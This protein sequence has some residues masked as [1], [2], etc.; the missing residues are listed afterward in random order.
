ME[1]F[2]SR[3]RAYHF[4]AAYIGV[5][6][7]LSVL[8]YYVASKS[9]F[10]DSRPAPMTHKFATDLAYYDM[11]RLTVALGSGDQATRVRLD[12]SLEVAKNDVGI[13][14][15]YQPRITARLNRF[16]TTLDPARIQEAGLMPWLRA[17]MLRQVN[18]AGAPV[19]V[20]DLLFRQLVVM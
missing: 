9:S 5:F 4:L 6:V 11:P 13:V 12:I 10:V 18:D 8:G 16:L 17:E 3:Y 19:P 20:H 14:E 7:M 2:S 1:V 15:G